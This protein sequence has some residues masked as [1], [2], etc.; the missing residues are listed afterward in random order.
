MNWISSSL[1]HIYYSIICL[2]YWNSLIVCKTDFYMLV[3]VQENIFNRR[4]PE[5]VHSWNPSLGA[6]Q[7]LQKPLL[8]Q[9]PRVR[10]LWCSVRSLESALTIPDTAGWSA[11]FPAPG[12]PGYGK[13]ECSENP[14]KGTRSV[15]KDF[16]IIMKSWCVQL[17]VAWRRRRMESGLYKNNIFYW[18]ESSLKRSALD[19]SWCGIAYA[20]KACNLSRDSV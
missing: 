15:M 17:I 14:W 2:I 9:W 12:C 20:G 7:L 19:I 8:E 18:V 10:P 1:S 3:L 6:A 13:Y 16:G 5:K 4:S 11:F